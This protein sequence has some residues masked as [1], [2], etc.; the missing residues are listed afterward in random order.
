MSNLANTETPKITPPYVAFPTFKSLVKNFQEHGIP[1]RIDRSVFQSFSVS[2]A[3]QL[4]P[5][6][7][8][9][10]LIDANN[11]PTETLKTLVA[12]YSTPAWPE[13]LGGVVKHA[14]GAL[15]HINLETASPSQFDEAFSKAYSG[16]ENVARKCKTFYLAAAA[17]AQIPISPYIMRNKKPRSGPTKKRSPR[18]NGSGSEASSKLPSPPSPPL[19]AQPLVQQ[20]VSILDMTKMSETEVEAVWT[21]LKYLRREGK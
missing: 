17:D 20:L 5:G 4:I 15:S 10:R 9:L 8:F 18:Q 21:L 7:R 19:M 6:L 12:T 1:G 14:Y 13:H 3:G 11:C 2:V 16:A